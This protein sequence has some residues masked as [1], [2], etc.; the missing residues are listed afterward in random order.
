MRS[1]VLAILCFATAVRA[2]EEQEV[3]CVTHCHTKEGKEFQQCVHKGELTC[4]ECHG[5]DPKAQRN[6]EKAHAKS[7]GFVGRIPREKVP[8]LCAR[9]H[10]DPRRMHAYDLPTDQLANYRQSGHGVTLATGDTSVAVCIDCHGVH[11]ILPAHDPRAPTARVNQAETCGRCHSNSKLMAKYGLPSDTAA[12]FKESVH[13]FAL[14]EMESPGAPSCT[15]CHGAHGANPPGVRDV[16]HVCAKCHVNTAEH[17]RKSPHGRTEDMRC[18]ACHEGEDAKTSRERGGCAACHGAHDITDPGATLYRGDGVG[19]CR[20]CHRNDPTVDQTIEAIVE[21]RRK[22]RD[23]MEATREDIRAAKA[24][25]VFL[26]HEDIYLRESERALVAVRPLAHSVD[27]KAIAAAL[28]DGARRQDRAREAIAKRTKVLRDHKLLMTGLA[29]ILLLL[30]A[31][32]GY[33]L[34]AVRRLS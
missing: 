28:D 9:C 7:A 19:H 18:G 8:E 22:L 25:G 12:K 10:S 30:T 16:V 3:S 29:F 5:G 27:R 31:L 15:D 23:A 24:K 20:H 14:I 33:K 4:M 11:R 21:G 32:L 26:E 2:Q 17:F 34:Q 1:A 6:K 13:G